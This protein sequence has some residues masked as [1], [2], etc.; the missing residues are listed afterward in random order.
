MGKA[1]KSAKGP[2]RARRAAMELF[3]KR[4][5]EEYA[6]CGSITA[7]ARVAGMGSAASHY[8]WLKSVPGYPEAFAEAHQKSI[9]VLEVE[10]RRRAHEGYLEPVFYKGV[11]VGTVRKFSDNLLMFLLR[12]AVPHKYRENQKIEVSGVDG[13]P[14][15]VEVAAA[16]AKV[17]GPTPKNPAACD[18][19]GSLNAKAIEVTSESSASADSLAHGTGAPKSNP[20]NMQ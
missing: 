15:R 3:R 20:E 11:Q 16:I 18:V 10:A 9:E 7:S 12:A 1:P 8:E 13:E 14:I 19:D 6:S 17:Y 5:L 4:F 2:T